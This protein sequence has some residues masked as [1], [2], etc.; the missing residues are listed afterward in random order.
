M[1]LSQI[2]S[3]WADDKPPLPEQFTEPGSGEFAEIA[4]YYDRLMS[5]VP[6]KSWVD[7]VEALLKRHNRQPRRVL[8]L[9]CGTGR[10]GSELIRRGYQAFGVDLSEPMVRYCRTQTPPLPA[11]TMDACQLALVPQ[12]LDL[13]VSLYD[14]LNY[15]L[16]PE[17]LEGCFAGARR[18]LTDEGIFIFDLNTELALR[19]G[20]F[21]QDNLRSNNPLKYSWRS[22][23]YPD[24]YPDR[25]ICRIDMEFRWEG[26]GGPQEFEEVHYERAYSQSEIKQML[27]GA[28]F[29]D[30][31]AY[32]GYTFKPPTARSD[33][34]FYV[35][36]K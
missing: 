8:D 32:N 34:V 12:S 18:S 13:I 33:R 27:A 5:S 24:W 4:P 25:G 19:T 20:L 10:V 30:I 7:Y 15:I 28:G 31:T 21:T 2:W 14:S 1:K 11:I 26:P 9:A 17:G 35:A 23:W 29:S 16:D 3:R 22:Y 6:Y 36:E